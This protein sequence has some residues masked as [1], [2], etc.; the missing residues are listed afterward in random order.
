L[1]DGIAEPST[2]S[3]RG[4][5]S[6]LDDDHVLPRELAVG[7]PWLADM[8]HGAMISAL[9]ARAVEAAPCPVPMQMT[10]LTC[11]MSRPVPLGPTQVVARVVRDGKRVQTLDVEMFVD[12][13]V[14][15]R[16]TALRVRVDP[17]LV[18][19]VHAQLPWPDDV[20]AQ[21]PMVST[22]ESPMGTS[23]LWNSFDPRWEHVTPGEAVVWVRLA[24]NL[25][26]G[27]P[28]T[29]TVRA[30]LA[31][32]LSM[33]SGAAVPRE[34]YLVINPDLTLSLTRPPVGEWIRISSRV[35]VEANGT[36]LTEATLSD[37]HGWVGRSLKSLLV[38]RR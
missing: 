3:Q 22:L 1:T 29:P 37:Q 7:P 6:R 19:D 31:A 33:T 21:G 24:Q 25:V 11:D 27:Q 20:V 8:Q 26:D 9:M 10:R 38:E 18:D 5:Y 13:A 15:S 14:R 34:H 4:Y 36:G 32:D 35:R 30:A 16:G 28:L 12:G 17:H 23:P 2:D